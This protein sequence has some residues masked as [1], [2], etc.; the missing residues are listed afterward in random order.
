MLLKEVLDYM[1]LEYGVD[2]LRCTSFPKEQW[3]QTKVSML[4]QDYSSP[5]AVQELMDAAVLWPSAAPAVDGNNVYEALQN[6]QADKEAA[7][8]LKDLKNSKA[9][10]AR[11]YAMDRIGTLVPALAN[12]HAV[13]L[14][15]TLWPMLD[16]TKA[17]P[18]LLQARSA[19]QRL[20]TV[21]AN[22]NDVWPVQQIQN[23]DPSTDP[24]W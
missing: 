13:N 22:I 20:R 18:E 16:T 19:L 6:Y 24:N 2:Y 5:S 17:S 11:T 1:G 4:Q 7:D 9:H 10:E 14:L 15:E 23:Y 8:T 21:E 12:E 3:G